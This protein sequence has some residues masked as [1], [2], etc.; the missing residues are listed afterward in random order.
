M[1]DQTVLKPIKICIDAAMTVIFLLLMGYHLLNGVTHEWLGVSL[2]VLFIAHNALNYKW[3]LAL[4]KGK[5]GAIRFIQTAINF[6]LLIAMISCIVS[7]I[8]ISGHVFTW[9]NA[10]SVSFGREL[11]LLATVWAF[12]LMALH[13]GLHWSY[14]VGKATKI[15][16]TSDTVSLILRWVFRAIVLAIC[17]YGC[18]NFI[19][20]KLWEEMFLMAEFKWFDYEKS[21]FLY[22]IESLSIMIMFATVSYYF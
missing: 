4:F 6:L 10:S 3:Y 2:F 13:L 1:K 12:I 14:F 15:V 11:H 9:L 20:R 16:K 17:A 7:A 5:Y 8:S 19:V 22:F 18:Y 21:V